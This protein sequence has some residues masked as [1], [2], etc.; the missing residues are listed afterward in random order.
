MVAVNKT[1]CA[2]SKQTGRKETTSGYQVT[3][4]HSSSNTGSE[5][6]K[7]KY[8]TLYIRAI[9]LFSLARD[10]DFGRLG[11]SNHRSAFEVVTSS[12]VPL[13]VAAHAECFSA[14]LVRTLEW[15]LTRM[16]VGVDS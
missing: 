7:R 8:C 11:G 2:C 14:S 3:E 12:F 10:R 9:A 1:C 16:R 15:L 5:T 6:R 4:C 13:H